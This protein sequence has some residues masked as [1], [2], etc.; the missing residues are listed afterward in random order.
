MLRSRGAAA[1]MTLGLWLGCGSSAA[2]DCVF[3]SLAWSADG[4]SLQFAAGDSHTTQV[5]RVEIQNGTVACV[6]PRARE[7]VW[8]EARQRALFHDAF[9]VYERRLRAQAP[10][11]LVFLSASANVFIRE[12]GCDAQGAL[13]VWTIDRDQLTH[14]IWRRTE[15]GVERMPG[16]WTGPEA[17]TWWDER[18][19][20]EP[21]RSA[22]GWRTRSTCVQKPHSDERLCLELVGANKAFRLVQA[23]E[24]TI[25]VVL[26]R[27]VPNALAVR[28]DSSQVVLGL[29]EELGA[30][31]TSAVLSLW[32]S[33]FTHATRLVETILRAP[34]QTERRHAASVHWLP[35]AAF[36]WADVAGQLWHVQEE[37]AVVWVGPPAAR[38]TA[39]DRVEGPGGVASLR[40]RRTQLGLM[41]EV[42]LETPGSTARLLVPAFE[43]KEPKNVP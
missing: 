26:D 34:M 2:S 41:S 19:V 9:G 31:G 30:D 14:A 33:D 37:G 6:E 16:E 13:L 36:L 28:V 35:G 11:A 23:R 38:R 10:R 25:D 39:A 27:C 4:Q 7:F 29:F 32:V 42:W 40:H 24:Q 3:S 20:A 18:N 12:V 17:R 5:L 22:G 43:A 21:S 8:D 1:A 15:A